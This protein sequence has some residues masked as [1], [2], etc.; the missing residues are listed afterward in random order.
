MPC[1]SFPL[2]LRNV[3]QTLCCS[4]HKAQMSH[5]GLNVLVCLVS[6]SPSVMSYAV[7]TGWCT[8]W[9]RFTVFGCTHQS[10]LITYVWFF[11]PAV[12]KMGTSGA[13][14]SIARGPMIQWWKSQLALSNKVMIFRGPSSKVNSDIIVFSQWKVQESKAVLL[15]TIRFNLNNSKSIYM[16]FFHKWV[17]CFH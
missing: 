12:L 17:C 14:W 4:F 2:H 7:T 3:F 16:L 1:N 6:K 8:E 15:R 5:T 11:K 9:S 13:F 10:W